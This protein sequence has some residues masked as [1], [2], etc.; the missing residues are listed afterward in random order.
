MT[1]QPP[2]TVEW[3]WLI[4]SCIIQLTHVKR[5]GEECP[6]GAASFVASFGAERGNGW[7]GGAERSAEKA[8][9]TGR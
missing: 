5:Q 3:S 7:G 6:V 2:K 1:G 8:T 4:F 9:H